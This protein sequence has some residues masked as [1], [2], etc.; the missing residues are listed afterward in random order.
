MSNA[1]NKKTF[2]K[3]VNFDFEKNEKNKLGPHIHYTLGAASLMDDP[4]LLKKRE[5]EISD[6]EQTIL[7]NISKKTTN[8]KKDKPMDENVVKELKASNDAL[9][10]KLEETVA[11]MEASE[12]KAERIEK[13]LVIEKSL[14]D[15]PF[16]S[17]LLC[18]VSESIVDLDEKTVETI[19]KAFSAM[20]DFKEPEEENE[21]Q[22][23]L[24]DEAGATGDGDVIEKSL[25]EQIMEARK[26]NTKGSK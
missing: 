10:K 2:L 20:N 18:E 16:D 4:L 3:N 22:K 26:K 14:N 6:E 13:K 19:I 23:Q 9:Q 11:K 8:Q 25:S 24:S 5:E 15:F 17:E 12:A 7:D 1:I 21:L